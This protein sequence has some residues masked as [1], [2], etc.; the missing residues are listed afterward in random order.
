M[1]QVASP[2][3][4]SHIFTGW[5]NSLRA[6][7][8]NFDGNGAGIVL[9]LF[10]ETGQHQ[11]AR[12]AAFDKNNSSILE[13]SETIALGHNLVNT[14]RNRD[15]GR[16]TSRSVTVDSLFHTLRRLEPT[17]VMVCPYQF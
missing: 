6:G 17:S 9:G 5:H 10:D 1:L 14:H 3:T 2:T 7:F 4:L 8:K 15:I 11:L 16:R 12:E 13:T